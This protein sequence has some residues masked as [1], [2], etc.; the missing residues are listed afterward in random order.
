[1]KSVT[2]LVSVA[3]ETPPRTRSC[4]LSAVS[5]SEAEP[6]VVS[7]VLA[8]SSSVAMSAT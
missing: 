1:M 5:A 6:V 4:A 3:G 8:G 7:K 2:Y